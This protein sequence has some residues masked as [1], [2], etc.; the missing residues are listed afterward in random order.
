MSQYTTPIVT[1]GIIF[2]ILV[3]F[4]WI[5][6]LIYMYRKYGF[7]PLS[8][9][10]ISFSFIFYFLSALF[11]VILPL[12]TTRDTCAMQNPNTVH[13]SLIPFQFVEDIL[14]GQWLNLKNPATYMLL[15]KQSAFYQVFFNFLLLL[16]LGVFLRYYLGDKKKW[17]KA[18]ILIFI[19]TFFFE[20]TQLTGIYG[21]YNCAYR[22]FDVDDLMTNTI[23]GIIG[24]F[25]APAVLAIFPSKKTIEERA[26]YL[27][28]KDEVKSMAVLLAIAIDLFIM[29]LIRQLVLSTTNHN[30]VTNFIVTTVLLI[31][32]QLLLPIIWNGRTIGSAIMRFRYSSKHS[33]RLTITRLTK[34]FIALYVAYFITVIVSTMNNITVTMDSVYYEASVLLSLGASI[35]AL[36]LTIVLFIHIMLVV[37]GKGKRRFFFDE[38]ADLY[39][40]RKK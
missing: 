38:S 37:F 25:I 23:G 4:L 34:R 26:E 24:F 2:I 33:K 10:L 7:L 5:P 1:A 11:L 35:A 20:I 27:L 32:G 19:T 36:I 18:A 17:W 12:P 8:T 22:L 28:E 15:F 21:I 16:P 3:F 31:C 9:T 29:D 13:Y 39:T 6:W 30:E 40:T 14:K